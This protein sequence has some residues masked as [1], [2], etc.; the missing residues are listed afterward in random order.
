MATVKQL[1]FPEPETFKCPKCHEA[2]TLY[3]PDGSDYCICSSCNSFIRFVTA[4][5]PKVQKNV[6]PV[7]AKPL[8]PLG[9][10]GTL[11]D[12]KFRVIAYLEKKEK[13]TSYGW[14]E[15]LLYNYEKGYAT[16]SEFNG[17]WNFIVDQTWEPSLEKAYSDSTTATHNNIDYRIFNKY[18]PVITGAIGEFDSDVMDDRPRVHEFIA[19]PFIIF[20][21]VGNS[22]SNKAQYFWGEY[23]EL[24]EIAEG[25]GLNAESFPPKVEIGAN[26]PS[27]QGA[28]FDT[29]AKVSILA[30]LAVLLVVFLFRTI[31]PER[32]L[33]NSDFNI[34]FERNSSD[35]TSYLGSSSGTY[36]YKPF[37][38]SSFEQPYGRT[39]LEIEV[40][41]NVDNSWMEAT[42]VLVNE[43]TNETWE[44]TKGIEYYHGYESG[45]SWSEGSKSQSI[46]LSKIPEGK[47][48]LNIYPASGDPTQTYLHIAVTANVLMWRNILLVWLLLSI[49]PII[50]YIRWTSFERKRWMNSD[51]S[52][53]E[54]DN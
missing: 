42:V 26:Q 21:E 45:E 50:S 53:Y 49:Y 51:Y 20:K 10:L 31:R 2:I 32:E 54:T 43:G 13:G 46:I 38:S 4:Y 12:H 14:K 5:T 16:L 19:P 34:S 40:R 47:Y 41:A 11:K 52:P 6:P 29:L 28:S 27:R 33:L 37:L 23:T 18:T 8:I 3:D 30:A 24:E 1:S 35:S 7:K 15:Y 36:E 48:H 25:F 22:G 17:H 9:A 39:T 44:V